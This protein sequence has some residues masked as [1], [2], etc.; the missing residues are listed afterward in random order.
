MEKKKI[1]YIVGA[2]ENF[3]TELEIGEM[4]YVIAADGGYQYLKKLG[5]PVNLVIGDFDSMEMPTETITIIKL[6]SE[7]DDTDMLAAIK[8]GITRGYTEFHIYGGTGGRLDHTLANIQC[9]VF[10]AKQQMQGY[11]YDEKHVMTVIQNGSI[12]FDET[13]EGIISVFSVSDK[14]EGVYEHGLKY[15]LQDATLTNATPIGV[16]N[17]FQ[18]KESSVSVRN[19]TLLLVYPI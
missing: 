2:G 11:L 1:C 17:E 8:E 18:K 7:K 12:S 10:L 15:T 6:P 4:D 13:Q 9:L 14:A 5:I 19:G 16:S 3:L